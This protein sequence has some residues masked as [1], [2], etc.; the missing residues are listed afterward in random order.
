MYK[1]KD[2]IESYNTDE[3]D[4]YIWSVRHE[5]AELKKTTE[6]LQDKESEEN[7]QTVEN[8]MRIYETTILQQTEDME[9]L[10]F[11]LKELVVTNEYLEQKEEEYKDLLASERFNNLIENVRKIKKV[12]EELHA[13]L[14]QRGIPPPSS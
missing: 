5:I 8:F 4:K 2:I 7:I 12:K 10:S 11:E 1:M 6:S 14:E 3:I 9:T 13:F